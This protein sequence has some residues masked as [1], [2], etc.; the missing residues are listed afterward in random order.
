MDSAFRKTKTK[1]GNPVL[2]FVQ[3]GNYLYG[4]WAE[5]DAPDAEWFAARWHL[6]GKFLEDKE[7][8]T[9]MDIII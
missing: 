6:D 5:S 2:I 8:Y 1:H 7:A 9:A 4:A 3:L